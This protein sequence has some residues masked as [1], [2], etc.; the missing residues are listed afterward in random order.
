MVL[1]VSRFYHSQC[2]I[3]I[4]FA[5]TKPV[6]LLICFVSHWPFGLDFLGFPRGCP[7][8]SPCA[9]THC[10]GLSPQRAVTEHLLS[11]CSRKPCRKLSLALGLSFILI[12][13]GSFVLESC[14]RPLH[15]L[16]KTSKKTFTKELWN[17]CSGCLV[18]GWGVFYRPPGHFF[19]PLG[20][21]AGSHKHL[22]GKP[23]TKLCCCH[24]P[25]WW[26]RGLG[27]CCAA[28][29]FTSCLTGAV[30]PANWE[31]TGPQCV[32]G[33]QPSCPQLQPVARDQPR[34]LLNRILLPTEKC[35]ILCSS[36]SS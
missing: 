21:A 22:K 17:C 5:D 10:V 31:G 7:S 11:L 15:N 16:R 24:P 35:L 29:F 33:Q 13:P 27:G 30:L 9:Y 23:S 34:L 25:S 3:R 19:S 28:R 6:F 4:D 1:H 32:W 18:N 12:L 14:P 36:C 20:L 26:M 8:I 2:E